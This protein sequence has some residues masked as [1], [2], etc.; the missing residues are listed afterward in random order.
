MNDTWGTPFI[1]EDI[2]N[3]KNVMEVIVGFLMNPIWYGN[4]YFGEI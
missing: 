1:P 3:P 4:F 2:Q